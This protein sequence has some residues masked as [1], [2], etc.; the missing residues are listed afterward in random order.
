[1]RRLLRKGATGT[2]K[3]LFRS[4]TPRSTISRIS[5]AARAT[6]VPL[7]L[8]PRLISRSGF[9]ASSRGN[10]KMKKVNDDT[11]PPDPEDI[12]PEAE[13]RRTARLEQLRAL[14][15]AAMLQREVAGRR[16]RDIEA[17]LGQLQ[18]ELQQAE[19]QMVSAQ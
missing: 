11:P 7:P 13:E 1:M 3:H 4:S 18:V 8:P 9:G 16:Q 5:L 15:D 2:C 6:R 19:P 12:D 10:Q 17:A 14:Y